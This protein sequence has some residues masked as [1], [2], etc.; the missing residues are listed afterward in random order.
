MDEDA[1]AIKREQPPAEPADHKGTRGLAG[2]HCLGEGGQ[3]W[4]GRDVRHDAILRGGIALNKDGARLSDAR[5][6]R[7][8][9][10]QAHLWITPDIQGLLRK[11]N[12]R[13][14]KEA[15]VVE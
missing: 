9:E 1:H 6:G 2:E 4:F 15:T 10:E 14:D 5:S 12:I 11:A 8:G 7:L 13:G 3:I